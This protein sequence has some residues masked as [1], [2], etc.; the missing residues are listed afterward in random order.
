MSVTLTVRDE[1]TAGDIYHE[2]PLEFPTERITI[3]ELIGEGRR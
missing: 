2:L 3:R 1:S